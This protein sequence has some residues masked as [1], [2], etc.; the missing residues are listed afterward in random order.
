MVSFDTRIG[1][2]RVQAQLVEGHQPHRVHKVHQT[3]SQ[4][5][6]AHKAA[7]FSPRCDPNKPGH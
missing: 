6:E 3:M 1:N 5:S 4:L 2:L 7:T